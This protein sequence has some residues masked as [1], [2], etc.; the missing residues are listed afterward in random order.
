MTLHRQKR[1][2]TLIELMVV[3]GLIGLIMMF[4]IPA[5]QGADQGGRVRAAV[6]QL[7]TTINLA[8]QTAITSRQNVHIL[9]PTNAATAS[10]DLSLVPY[11]SYAVYG[12]RDHY[13]GEW[14]KLPSGVVFDGRFTRGSESGPQIRNIFMQTTTNYTKTVRFPYTSD[15]NNFERIVAL[16]YRPD[17]ALS[18]AGFN[19]KAVYLSSGWVDVTGSTVIQSNRPNVTVFGIE[20]RPESGQSRMREYNL[21]P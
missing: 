1:A 10:T 15:S 17:G 16:T 9:F 8:R 5:F 7:N 18:H 3:V 6:F 14:R 19:P 13:L 20:I 11:A 2:F 4:A 21:T 12:E